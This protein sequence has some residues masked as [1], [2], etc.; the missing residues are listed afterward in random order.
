MGFGMLPPSMNLQINDHGRGMMPFPSLM[1]PPID[2]N[3]MLP[4]APM[5]P[6]PLLFSQPDS[7]IDPE[8]LNPSTAAAEPKKLKLISYTPE[9]LLSLQ[10]KYRELPEGMKKLDFPNKINRRDRVDS[11]DSDGMYFQKKDRKFS[12]FRSKDNRFTKGSRKMTSK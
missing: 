11:E 8:L 2:L 3:H 4:F 10:D 12:N 9:F 1:G 6:P 5:K 7:F